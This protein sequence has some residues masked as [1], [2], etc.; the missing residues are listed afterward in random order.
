MTSVQSSLLVA[1]LGALSVPAAAQTKL[2]RF[3]DVRKEQVVFCYAG[4]LWLAPSNGGSATRLTAHPGIELFPK[5]SPDGQWIA[6]TG[7]Y[8]GDEQVYVIPARGGVPTQ[9]TFYPARGPL[10]ARWGFDNQVYGWSRDSKRVLFRS[11]REG[12]DLTDT[13]LYFVSIDGGAPQALPMPVAGGGDLS[14]DESKVVYSPLTRDFRTWKRYQGGWA[15]D[16]FVFDLATSEMTPVAH[17]VRTERDP[18]WIG[19]QIYFASDRDGTL[20]LYSFDPKGGETQQ[21]TTSKSWDVRWPSKGE[22]G[23]IVYELDGELWIFDTTKRASRKL[24]ITVPD[25]GLASR[26]S[27]VAVGDAIEDFALSPKG[28]RALFTARG[29][30]FTAPIEHGPSRNLTRS[31]DAHER[32]AEWSPDGATIAFVS[33][34]S[35]E[36]ELWLVAQDG[37]SSPV[38]LTSGNDRRIDGLRWAPDSKRIAFNDKSNRLRVVDVASKSITDVARNAGGGLGDAT[39]SPDS[40]WLAFSLTDTNGFNSL[41]IWGGGDGQLHRV[42]DELW[43]EYEPVWDPKGNYLYYLSDRDYHP[44]LWSSLEWN[45]ATNR[46]TG[47]YALALRKDVAHPLPPRSD[48]VTLASKDEAKKPADAKD[49]DKAKEGEKPEDSK[50]DG[51]VTAL[52]IDFDGLASRVARLPIEADNYRSLNA[53]AG[54]LL[55]TRSGAPYYGRESERPTALMAFDFEKREASAVLDEIGGYTLSADGSKM[56]VA[57]GGGFALYDAKA[58]AKDSKK[59][60][61]TANLY[62]DRIPRQEWNTIF[63]EVWRRYRDYFYVDNMHG[64]DWP[65]LRKQ[66]EQLLPHVGH[67]ADLNYVM[68]EMIAELN[69]GHA[70]VTGG[71]WEVPARPRVALLGARLELDS[72]AGRYKI[73]RILRGQNQEERYRS[74]LTEIGVDVKVGEY[75]LAI[76]G[77]D[78]P[79]NVDPYK[80]LRNKADNPVELLVGAT[81]DKAAARKVKIRPI[82]SETDLNY[83][84]FVLRN[85]ERVD[86]LSGGRFAYIHIPDM[87]EDGIA[88]FIKWYYGQVR[89]VG[90]I[91]DDRNNGGGNVS[92]MVIER[93]RRVLLST[94]FGRNSDYTETYPSVVFNGPMVCLLNE[95]SASDGDIFPW[96]FKTSGLGPLIGKRSWGGV[97][98]ITNHGPL[99]DGGTVNVPEFGNNDRNGQWAVEGHGVDPDIVVENDAK[100]VLAGR[101]PQLERA[102]QELQKLCET[103][104]A[105]L[106]GKPAAPVKTK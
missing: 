39:W 17:H 25:D 62:A 20:N 67:R 82:T 12:W 106:P 61:S 57:A 74:P 14:P 79:G 47:V 76:D 26:P 86:K 94:G 84:E 43:N 35:G 37:A 71:D 102:V 63:A 78:L 18:M 9:L 3:P 29:D 48:E 52:S 56:L 45:F 87:G 95:N 92:Q 36:E 28:E 4:D 59:D 41:Y 8:D 10:P 68:G 42:T 60:V 34:K 15:Q 97:V 53:N 73:A 99:L 100:S 80:L 7:Q 98:G 72:A 58:G 19:G 16:L 90:L 66:Y 101:D 54:H 38:Q 6:F 75:L 44:Q 93:L 50:K 70:Y 85:R 30:V 2:L 96:M 13:R 5:F 89:K 55:F 64:Y 49:G 105:A 69:V 83:L 1:L 24:D 65:A 81:T 104:K 21:L 88:E 31:S 33:D 40:R 22:D 91:V 23:E 77:E 46:T 51:A 32:A 27:R 11:M 103:R